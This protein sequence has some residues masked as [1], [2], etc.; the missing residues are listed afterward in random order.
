M[1]ATGAAAASTDLDTNHGKPRID[2]VRGET[3]YP[4]YAWAGERRRASRRHHS[5][6]CRLPAEAR[7]SDLARPLD[8]SGFGVHRGQ[9]GPSSQGSRTILSLFQSDAV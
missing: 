9:Q 1:A 2:R 7:P 6:L 8:P 4:D 5:L 3:Q